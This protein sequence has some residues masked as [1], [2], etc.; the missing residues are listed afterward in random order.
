MSY[1]GIQATVNFYTLREADL[2]NE[3]TNIMTNITQASGDSMDLVQSTNQSKAEVRN[4]YT[5]G[6]SEYEAQMAQINDGYD[7]KL[8]QITDWEKELETKKQTLET[9]IQ[10]TT[11]YKESFK[12]SLKQNIQKDFKYGGGSSASG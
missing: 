11:S 4:T 9:E 1:A 10:A 8:A 12:S 5:P 2:T 6:T 7:L 3:L